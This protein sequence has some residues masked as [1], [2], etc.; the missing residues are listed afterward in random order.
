MFT[1]KTLISFSM[2]L[3]L[4]ASACKKDDSTEG[5]IRIGTLGDS[6]TRGVANANYPGALDSLIPD[7]Y[8]ISNYAVAA[9]CLVKDCFNPI[10][11]TGEF[12]NLVEDEPDIITIMLGTNDC[13]PTNSDAVRANY[14]R[15]CREMIDLFKGFSSNPRILICY[16]PP[17]HAHSMLIDSLIR[18]EIIPIIDKIA[19]DYQ[20]EVVDTY[21][22]V[23][24]YPANYPDGLHP[25]KGGAETLAAIVKDALGL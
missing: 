7:N 2:F 4:L 22:K 12:S 10:W 11:E 9:T 20:L 18:T 1:K 21:Y 25:G 6:I 13:N 14:D 5:K 8:I 16:P 15:D 3:C 17:I 23:D 19:E 24:D